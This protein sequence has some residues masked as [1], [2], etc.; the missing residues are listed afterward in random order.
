M[1]VFTTLLTASCLFTSFAAVSIP[2]AVEA[3]QR[4]RDESSD[5]VPQTASVQVVRQR[6]EVASED[7]E[8]GITPLTIAERGHAADVS[9]PLSTKVFRQFVFLHVPKIRGE[10]RPLHRVTT[11]VE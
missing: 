2:L 6:Q 1:L 5:L 9:D 4:V 3:A 10:N 11:L 7:E 8:A